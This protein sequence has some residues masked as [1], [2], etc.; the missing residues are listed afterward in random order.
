[1][2]KYLSLLVVLASC[3]QPSTSAPQSADVVTRAE[4]EAYKAASAA[5]LATVKAERDRAKEQAPAAEIKPYIAGAPWGM[6]FGEFRPAS[7]NHYAYREQ[8]IGED[9]AE[10]CFDAKPAAQWF[11]ALNRALGG[12][13]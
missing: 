3:S 2:K 6:L 13:R 4:F 12:K 8:A 7:L 5:E 10:I 1:M 9:G 11:S